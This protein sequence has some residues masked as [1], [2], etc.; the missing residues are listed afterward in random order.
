MTIK[1]KL[2]FWPFACLLLLAACI[3]LWFTRG[4]GSKPTPAITQNNIVQ[5]TVAKLASKAQESEIQVGLLMEDTIRLHT[6]LKHARDS[7][8]R[9]TSAIYAANSQVTALANEV[10]DARIKKDTAGFIHACDTLASAVK[11]QNDKFTMFER[12][13]KNALGKCDA[14][15]L[16]KSQ[17]IA[18]LTSEANGYKSAYQLEKKQ[19]DVLAKAL[20]PKTKV[21]IGLEAWTG[22]AASGVGPGIMYQDKKERI[23]RVA[24]GL[25]TTGNY[26]IGAS[27]YLK[28]QFHK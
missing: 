13:S 26:W 25:V 23:Y 11:S 20:T 27:A 18:S 12:D 21:Y 6:E 22:P 5:D 28:L 3:V 19:N 9:S 14:L 15:S 17:M 16:K 24:A 7:L 8:K 1:T 4:C 10:A 2:S